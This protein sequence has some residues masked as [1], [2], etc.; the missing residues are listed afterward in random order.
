MAVHTF[1]GHLL[2]PMITPF[3]NTIYVLYVILR[4]L[5]IWLCTLNENCAKTTRVTFL[6]VKAIH[7]CIF[8]SL[9][10]S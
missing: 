1:L 5:S 3:T 4:T 8:D 7:V 2:S 6:D 9:E 10:I